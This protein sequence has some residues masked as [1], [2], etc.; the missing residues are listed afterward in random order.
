MKKIGRQVLM[1]GTDENNCRNG[2]GAFLRLKDG[3]IMYAYTRFRSGD[4]DDHMPADIFVIY[5]CDEGET[6]SEPKVI[7]KCPYGGTNYMCISLLRMENGDI[8]LFALYKLTW[9]TDDYYMWRSSDEGETWSEKTV[10]IGEPDTYYV[11]ENDRAVRLKS[12]RIIVPANLCPVN[13]MVRALGTITIFASDDDGYSWY[14]LSEGVE[15]PTNTNSEVGLQ[16]TDIF[17]KDDGTLIAYSRTDRGCQYRCESTDE[18]KTWS[19]PYP[20]MFFTSPIAPIELMKAK[21]G[22]YA[23]FNPIPL[24]T[25][26]EYK[27]GWGKSWGRTPFV[28]AISRDDGESFKELYCLEDDPENGYCYGAMFEGDDYI[29]VAYYH[30]NDT[31]W[32]LSANK[33]IKI[34]KSELE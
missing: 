22:V 6:W 21:D 14:K 31:G 18:G 7:M 28:M 16:E 3:R 24:Y 33:I 17:Q 29:L 4:G 15:L 11:I 30:S 32:V 23:V 10:I 1:L 26:R 5:S 20:D 25:G 34:M 13:D 9:C 12:G 2:E 8:G 27:G 19:E